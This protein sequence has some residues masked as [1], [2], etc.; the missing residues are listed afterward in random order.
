MLIRNAVV[1]DFDSL[2]LLYR[3]LHP[4][5]PTPTNGADL[6]VF[7]HILE[8]SILHLFVASIEDQ[9]L[10][11]S[12]YLN[13]I[14]NMTRGASPYAVIENVITREDLRGSGIGKIMMQHTLEF[15]WGQGCYKAMLQTGSKQES[16]H[17]FYRACGF[18]ADDKVGYVARPPRVS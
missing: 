13:I 16:T 14:P 1:E 7:R 5:D 3:Q 6:R 18:R 4:E 2:R 9:N 12:T 10:I 15:A 11:A 17:G 8:S